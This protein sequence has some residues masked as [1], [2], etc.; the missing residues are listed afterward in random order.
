M[1]ETNVYYADRL[2]VA[3]EILRHVAPARVVAAICAV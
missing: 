1:D 2:N 3:W